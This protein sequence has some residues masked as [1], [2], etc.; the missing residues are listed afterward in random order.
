MKKKIKFLI[1]FFLL[2]ILVFLGYKIT[3]KLSHKQKVE[4][5]TKVVP[6]FS[7][8]TTKDII[9]T[10]KDLPNKPVV[11]VYFNSDCDF[12]KSEATKIEKHLIDFKD[13]Q[14]V[15]VSFEEKET[16]E[17]FATAYKLNNKENVLFL[18]DKK[19]VFS[20]LFDVNSIPYIV[21]YNKDKELLKKFKGAT[22]I[23]A[24]LKVLE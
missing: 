19:G 23:D 6:N 24:I 3:S 17:K 10:Q 20:K 22:K 21:I 9:Y 13:T 12:C 14:L 16:I 5:C 15:F 8:N 4:E 11:F 18:E 1:L 7:F 2:S